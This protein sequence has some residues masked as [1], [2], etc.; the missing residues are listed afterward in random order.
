MESKLILLI[1]TGTVAISLLTGCSEKGFS[2]ANSKNNTSSSISESNNKK[3]STDSS[4]KEKIATIKIGA[5]AAKE[6]KNLTKEKMLTYAMQDEYLAKKEYQIIMDKYGEQ[7]PFSNIIKAETSHISQ[8]T[9]LLN[10]YNIPIPEDTSKDHVVLPPSLNEAYKTGVAAE[11]DNIAM[12]ENFLKENLPQDIKDTF[13]SLRD[14]S[15]NHLA[16]FQKNAR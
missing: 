3:N 15:K 6:D 16:A 9:A 4:S 13:I 7:K 5:T 2:S 8:L 1:I 12:Y 14:A 10:K 11:I